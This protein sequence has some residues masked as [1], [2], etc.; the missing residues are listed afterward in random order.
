MKISLFEDFRDLD[1]LSAEVNLSELLSR[2]NSKLIEEIR[3]LNEKMDNLENIVSV[4][5]TTF[6]PKKKPTQSSLKLKL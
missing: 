2:E 4:M 5:Q 3:E 1:N 6:L